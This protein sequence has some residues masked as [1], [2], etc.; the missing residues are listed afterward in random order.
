M[1]SN[2]EQC[3]RLLRNDCSTGY[4]NIPAM[5]LKP[6]VE[7]LVLPL[8]FVINNYIA[9]N[10]FPD[11]WKTARINPIPKI[12]QPVELK[13]HRPVS[14]LSVLSKVYEKFVLQ[15]LTVFINRESV[16]HQN[17]P[18][19]TLLLKLHDYINKTMKSS[20]VTIAIFTNY[21]KAFDTIGFS[22][23]IKTI[24]TLNFSKRFL[25][26][27][28]NYLTDRRHFVQ[29]DSSISNI[30]IT[31]FGVPKG[32]ILGPILF[33]LCV[34]DITNILSE[35]Q[36]IQCPDDCTIYKSCKTK[37]V[38]K[39][40]SELENELKLL[41]QWSKNTNLVFNCKKTKSML[42]STRKMSQHHQLY[43][44]DILKISC[45]NQT[46]ER[47][48]Q[49]KL[50]G[51]VIDE[52]FEL[53]THV[54]NIFKNGYSTLKI[55]KKLKRY[56]SYQTR[57][58]LVE[59]LILSKIDYCNVLFKGLPKYQIQRVNKLI[60]ACAGFVKYKYRELK[61]IAYLNWLLIEERIDFALMK[62]VFNGLNNKNMPEHLQLKLSKEK[63]SLRKNSFMLVHQI[64]NINHAYL[65]GANKVFKDLPNEIQ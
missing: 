31:N 8:T 12:T 11:A 21:L 58:H 28:F 13:D 59:S 40:S 42:F 46:I 33:N 64:E 47:V 19:A 44:N 22:I 10:N 1:P 65:E 6:V 29:I 45:N 37:D 61:D 27:V 36:C 55:L 32:S 5:F 2:V 39:C 50:L 48:Q 51:V 35:S 24:H 3:L 57:K 41:E 23:L 30:L 62:L 43:N 52:H 26:W 54:R 15:Q 18:T 63:R 60:Q 4:D 53:Y 16:Y 56:T 49:Y 17:H 7:F 38:T 34:A 9:T 25:Y 20:E 14:I